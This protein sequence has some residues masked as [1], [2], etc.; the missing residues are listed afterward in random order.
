[1]AAFEREIVAWGPPDWKERLRLPWK[2]VISDC[3]V[4]EEGRIVL[5]DGENDVTIF[6]LVTP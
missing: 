2:A 1:M 4:T 5:L 6:E 3:I